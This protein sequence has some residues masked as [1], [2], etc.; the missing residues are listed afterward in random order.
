MY[1]GTRFCASVDIVMD[2]PENTTLGDLF[3][4]TCGAFSDKEFIVFEDRQ[5]AVESF[6]YAQAALVVENYAAVFARH[7]I[8]KGSRVLVHMHN[9][10]GY[11]FT[12]FACAKLGAIMVPLNVQAG[13]YELD[14][15]IEHCGASAVVTEPE[16]FER[17]CAL[18]K[19]HP[20][21]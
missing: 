3:D 16:S 13:D 10:P 17:F 15:C 4:C 5:G 8:T 6:T 2:L 11:L 18:Q 14:Y 20:G 12:W 9:R 7:G 1:G 21:L 19:N